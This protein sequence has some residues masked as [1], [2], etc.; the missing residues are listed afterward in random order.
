[1]LQNLLDGVVRGALLQELGVVLAEHRDRVLH[2]REG[3]D[4]VLLFLVELRALLRADFGRLVQP[5]G[6]LP[7]LLLRLGDRRIELPSL[8]GVLANVGVK[9]VDTA[10]RS[11]NGLRLGLLV[12]LAPAPHFLEKLGVLLVLG[13]KLTLHV[14]EKLDNLADRT[15][16]EIHVGRLKGEQRGRSHLREYEYGQ[17]LCSFQT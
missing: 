11:L 6:V 14:L 3:L 9:L 2:R 16:L 10:V 8:P 15:L 12:R 4:D 17:H 7:E 5:C 1:V 13:L